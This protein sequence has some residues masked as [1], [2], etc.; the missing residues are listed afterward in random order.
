MA[1]LFFLAGVPLQVPP[2]IIASPTTTCSVD[3]NKHAALAK[4]N[5]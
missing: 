1:S 2:F 4:K 3:C 5:P